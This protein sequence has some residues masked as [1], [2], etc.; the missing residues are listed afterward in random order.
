LTRLISYDNI[1]LNDQINSEI[2]V[3]SD[4][5]PREAKSTFYDRTYLQKGERS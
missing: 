1:A 3:P 4:G 2:R 5:E